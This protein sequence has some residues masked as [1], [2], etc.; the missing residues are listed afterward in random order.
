MTT[1]QAPAD[2]KVVD[3]LAAAE[4]MMASYPL[5]AHKI[6][7]LSD[8]HSAK[9]DLDISLDMIA[10]C[11]DASRADDAGLAWAQHAAMAMMHS[12]VVFYVRATK[13]KSDHRSTL[14]IRAKFTAEQRSFHD[15][16]CH[17]R[18]DAVAHY[19]P[20]PL[21]SGHFFHEEKLLLPTDN[22]EGGRVM[23]VS[24]R[25]CFAP[26]FVARFRQHLS[27]ALLL[28]Q[29]EV[30]KR[31][32]ALLS[33]IEAHP[34]L[35]SLQT[36]FRSHIRPASDAMGSDSASAMFLTGSREGGRTVYESDAGWV[37]SGRQ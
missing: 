3:L 21:P 22:P 5:V 10:A 34:D 35:T 17:L 28:V 23:M 1:Q 31:E 26:D 11:P 19:G 24:R 16:L 9:V 2:V 6:T 7:R 36:L 8:S 4:E 14:D 37:E 25:T 27:R 12:A 13:S 30:H 29:R 20:G 18:D 32:A 15:L 33:D